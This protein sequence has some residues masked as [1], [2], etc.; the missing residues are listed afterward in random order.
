TRF[1]NLYC[2]PQWKSKEDDIPSTLEATTRITFLD[3]VN[4][5]FTEY[6]EDAEIQIEKHDY[7]F[8]L[9]EIT[10][11]N[12][13]TTSWNNTKW[14]TISLPK[15]RLLTKMDKGYVPRPTI[16]TTTPSYLFS[17]KTRFNSDRP[18]IVVREKAYKTCSILNA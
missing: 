13:H 9:A 14:D 3:H 8:I 15:E 6:P 4:I 16:Q 2:G 5:L 17:S 10:N 7:I 18:Y 12:Y 11:V 1:I